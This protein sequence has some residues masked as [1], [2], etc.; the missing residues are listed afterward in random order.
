MLN[1]I[2][3]WDAGIVFDFLRSR[4]WAGKANY[5]VGIEVGVVVFNVGALQLCC[6]H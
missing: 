3:I 2:G 1:N 5:V 4:R 6:V